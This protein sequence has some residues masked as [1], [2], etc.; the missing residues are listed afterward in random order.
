MKCQ[1]EQSNLVKIFW[2]RRNAFEGIPLFFV[3][4]RMTGISRTICKNLIRAILSPTV[5]DFVNLALK[6]PQST[7][8]NWVIFD[9][10]YSIIF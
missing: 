8:L 10:W 9:K 7:K 5:D 2:N 3:S 4:T 1:M 6:S